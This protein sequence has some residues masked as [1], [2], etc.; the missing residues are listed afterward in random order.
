MHNITEVTVFSVGDSRKVGTWSNV[1]YCLTE[2]LLAKNI[3]VNRVN[4]GMGFV[5]K[6]V[7]ALSRQASALLSLG[8]S[9]Y[10][11]SRSL[12]HYR[13]IKRRIA[14]AVQSYPD[15][16]VN[17]FLTFSFS[18]AGLSRQT[19]VLF[20]D[21]T[22]DHWVNQFQGREPNSL[23]R[24]AIARENSEIEAA[25]WVFVLF[26]GIADYMKTRYSNPRIAYLGNVVNS[27]INVGE[28]ADSIALK[29][30]SQMLLFIG[31]R[32][33]RQGARRLIDAFWSLK[34]RYPDLTVNIVG[35]TAGDLGSV[36][37]GVTC[38]GYLDKGKE[39]ERDLYYALLR[40]ARGIVN[41]TSKWAAFSSMIEAMHF[42]TPVVVTPYDEFV[43]TFS[44]DIDFGFYCRDE[45]VQT[46]CTQIEK[47]LDEHN[48]EA[49]CVKAHEAVAEFTWSAY[50]DRLLMT[51]GSGTLAT[52]QPPLEGTTGELRSQSY[53]S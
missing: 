10:G 45:G 8:N 35:M 28:P 4:L 16:D 20:A 18:S 17:I 24:A 43:R 26:P 11:Y 46:L 39:Q 6:V 12:L 42:Y 36:P 13:A 21:W 22:L 14:R 5:A 52:P 38:H 23:E 37:P 7:N 51:I 47:L 1:P 3:K 49:R 44:N 50:V 29:R 2:T 27:L 33:Y 48:Y 19:T 9:D 41:T 30:K 15:A 32:Q 34:P 53:Q 25:D 31:R 40:N